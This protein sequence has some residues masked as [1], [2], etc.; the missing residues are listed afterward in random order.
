MQGILPIWEAMCMQEC[1]NMM[2]ESFWMTLLL[3][4]LP[5]EL[6]SG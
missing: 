1:V 5:T 3:A 2:G 6:V 4:L